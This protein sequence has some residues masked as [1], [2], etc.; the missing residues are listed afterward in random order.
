MPLDCALQLWAIR[1]TPE[2]VENLVLYS[3][4]GLGRSAARGH[5]MTMLLD[6]ARIR[7]PHLRI[8]RTD[9]PSA[10]GP[11]DD[12]RLVSPVHLALDLHKDASKVRLDGP[13]AARS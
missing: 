8:E 11:E 7:E 4:V 1:P 10:F 6:V 9:E 2:R 5:R 13:A 12:Y 3:W